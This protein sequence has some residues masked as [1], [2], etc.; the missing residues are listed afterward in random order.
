MG[1]VGIWSL[2]EPDAN[3]SSDLQSGLKLSESSSHPGLVEAFTMLVPDCVGPYVDSMC[4]EGE[5]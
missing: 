4:G 1:L 5:Q 3:L 2:G